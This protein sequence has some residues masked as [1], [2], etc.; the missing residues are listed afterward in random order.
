ML[1]RLL[2]V[3][4]LAM[5]VGV[6]F[7]WALRTPPPPA[8]PALTQPGAPPLRLLAETEP[9]STEAAAAEAVG[10]PQSDA[11]RDAR[12]CIEIGPFLTQVDL[13]R[14]MNALTPIVERIQF[15]ET[16]AL[17]RRGYR[18]FIAPSPSREAALATARQLAAAGLRDYFV[19]TNGADQNT[20]SLGLYRELANAERRRTE[21]AALG[22]DVSMEPRDDEIP[23]YWIDLDIES[24]RDW[25]AS[26][27]GYSGVGSREIP[28]R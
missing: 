12:Q 27:G 10:P 8:R 18:V 25:R 14:A 4:L 23:Q 20:V 15:R 5:N 2:V 22:L 7:W 24:D 9:M 21:V 26:L 13:R 1:L 28:C 17:I 19:V 11:E 3:L 6:A 16:R